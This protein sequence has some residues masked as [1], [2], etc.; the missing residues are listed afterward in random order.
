MREHPLSRAV[1]VC[2]V[3]ISFLSVANAAVGAAPP[4]PTL[5]SP[6]DGS[7]VI[8]SIPAPVLVSP[9]N[10]AEV[11]TPTLQWQA[12]G[13]AAYYKV[14]L[15]KNLSFVPLEA[16]FTTYNTTLT[17]NDAL[18]P[19][20]YYWRVSGVDGDDVAGT[21]SGYR[22]FVLS[23]APAPVDPTPQLLAPAHAA[24]LTS[25]PTFRWTRMAGADHYRL[26]VSTDAGFGTT[27]DSVLTDYDEYTPYDAAGRATFAPDTYYW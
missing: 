21:A 25:D 26:V 3:L 12:A 20:T 13:G 16:T 5:L 2:V 9:A 24:T 23:A 10:G 15:S 17:P 1:V 19:D 4:V 6:A 22:S 18:T 11:T 7:S 8:N 27:Y 14:E